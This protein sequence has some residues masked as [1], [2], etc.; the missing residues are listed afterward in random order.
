MLSPVAL[1]EGAMRMARAGR[2]YTDILHHYFTDVH[3]VDITTLDFFRDEDAEV[4]V[5]PGG[6]KR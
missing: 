3:L 2:S 5:A 1:T 6:P 4:P